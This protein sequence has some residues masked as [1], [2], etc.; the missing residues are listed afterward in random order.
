MALGQEATIVFEPG[1]EVAEVPPGT[2]ILEAAASAGLEIWSPCGGQGTCG[3]CKAVVRPPDAA[4]PLTAAERERLSPDELAQD[5]RLCCQAQATADV[6]VSLPKVALGAAT[7]ILEGGERRSV[8]R[9]PNVRRQ[10]VALPLPSLADQRDDLW[11]LEAA[12]ALEPGTLESSLEAARRLPSLL[13]HHDSQV[14]ATVIG[15]RLVD[16]APPEPAP[17]CL[18]MAFDVG[19][20]TVVGYLVDLNTGEE[21]TA[22]SALNAQAYYGEDVISRLEYLRREPE[23]GEQ[24]RTA[25]LGV[26]NALVKEA[27]AEAEVSPDHIY[28]VIMVGNT[29]MHHLFLGLDAANI[30]VTPFTPV[31]TR[32]LAVSARELGLEMSPHAQVW[33]LPA[34]AGYVGADIVG[35]LVATELDARPGPNML[36]D[37]GTNGEVCLW[38]GEDLLCCSCA[39]GPAFEGAQISR[40]TRA[41]PGAIERVDLRDGDTSVRT[42]GGQPAVGICGSGLVDAV[43][44]LLELG[45]LE[46]T[47]RLADADSADS[48]PAA[49]SRL[50]GSGPEA[51]LLLADGDETD[52]GRALSLTQA[53]I[54][55]LQLASAAVRA[56]TEV[57]LGRAG[58]RHQHV[59][60][61]LLAGAFGSYIR[62]ASAVR[63]G[64]LPPLPLE[65]VRPVGNAAGVGAELCLLSTDMRAYA[66]T[67]AR[68]ATYVELSAAPEFEGSYVEAMILPTGGGGA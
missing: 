8:P 67:L 56:G 51:R 50:R 28:E 49:R 45:L 35:A 19:T 37:I 47:G 29:T 3:Q 43:A 10:R 24:L 34:V 23:A 7:R 61:L 11:R 32:P 65:R 60:E 22:V 4:S 17:S 26:V 63:I 48:T 66:R 25:V 15:H 20:T 46:E 53:D 55:Q 13:R 30:A 62:P 38:T 27:C 64:L 2:S 68:K 52:D 40:G 14:T 9:K 33:W 1:G 16:V 58:L 42:I 36:V 41:V 5:Y 31:A 6:V 59:Q 54:R 39:A 21:L 44:C 57:L 18:G 12:L